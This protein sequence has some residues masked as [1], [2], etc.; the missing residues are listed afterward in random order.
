MVQTDFG[1]QLD[2]QQ[3]GEWLCVWVRREDEAEIDV[4]MSRLWTV[5]RERHAY[6]LVLELDEV[7][8]LSS[9]LIGHLIR[10][11]QQIALQGGL[12]RL[13]GLSPEHLDALELFVSRLGRSFRCF[14]NREAALR[15]QECPRPG[16]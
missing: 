9:R 4:F 6:R 16:G 2:T 11:E 15:G 7:K 3:V 8:V 5:L 1:W 12:L 10:L 13:S 14:P